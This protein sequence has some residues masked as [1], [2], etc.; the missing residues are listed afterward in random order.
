MDI[1][2]FEGGVFSH[3]TESTPQL[4]YLINRIILFVET[5]HDKDA[6]LNEIELNVLFHFIDND[7][8]FRLYYVSK[9]RGIIVFIIPH[10]L[11]NVFGVSGHF[12]FYEKEFLFG[13]C[14]KDFKEILDNTPR[15][16]IGELFH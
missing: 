4:R 1:K 13:D 11:N 6:W 10:S 3:H 7:S 8:A 16:L 5:Y 2:F 12:Q 9:I 15:N 14:L